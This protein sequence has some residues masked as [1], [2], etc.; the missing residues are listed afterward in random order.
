MIE[1]REDI[2]MVYVMNH[3][4]AQFII[5]LHCLDYFPYF[6]MASK[7]LESMA[8]RYMAQMLSL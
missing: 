8:K 7:Q 1:R 2:T 4:L 3:S 6:V 5:D